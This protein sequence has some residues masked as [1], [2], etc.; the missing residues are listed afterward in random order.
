MDTFFATKNG[1]VSSRGHTCCQLFV[2]DKGYVYVVPMKSCSEV[3]QAVKQFVSEVG[4]PD[5]LICDAT[6]EQK[7]KNLKKFLGE[8]GTRLKVLERGTPWAY[9]AELLSVS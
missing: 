6:L 4:A 5:V 2:T 9:K 3:L 1:G 8:I 7:S